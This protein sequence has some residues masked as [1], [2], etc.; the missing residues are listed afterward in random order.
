[1]FRRTVHILLLVVM[2]WALL[3]CQQGLFPDDVP[4]TQYERFDKRRG[5]FR[6]EETTDPRGVPVPDLRARLSVYQ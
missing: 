4:R 6:P 1:M 5:V 3:G 2:G